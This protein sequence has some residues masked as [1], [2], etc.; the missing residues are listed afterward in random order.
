M[1]KTTE[2]RISLS[3]EDELHI[4]FTK[5]QNEFIEVLIVYSTCINTT[6]HQVLR[7]DQSHGI[8]HKDKLFEPKIENV[9]E[10]ITEKI[11]P[12]LLA[13]LISEIKTDWLE[14]KRLFIKNKLGSD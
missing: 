5:K 14:L 7:I 4:R 12:Q 9:K 10:L 6:W 11:T 8:L 13:E 3:I 1:E 2:F